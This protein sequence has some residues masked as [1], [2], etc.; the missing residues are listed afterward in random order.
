MTAVTLGP[1]F[2]AGDRILSAEERAE[3]LRWLYRRWEWLDVPSRQQH[4][5][6]WSHPSLDEKHRGEGWAAYRDYMDRAAA[7][8]LGA[9][10]TSVY[11]EDAC[12][13]SQDAAR[14][15]AYDRAG[16][17]LYALVHG[18]AEK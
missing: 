17:H 12:F 6:D 3:N 16:E 9:P 8:M 14:E 5:A 11:D 15:W 7:L 10:W 13:Q 2:V 4:L 1:V 18:E